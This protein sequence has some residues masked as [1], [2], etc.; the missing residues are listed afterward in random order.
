[1]VVFHAPV[2]DPSASTV[3]AASGMDECT[4]PAARPRTSTLR[5]LSGLAGAVSGSAAIILSTSGWQATCGFGLRPPHAS[6]GGPPGFAGAGG[7]SA[8]LNPAATCATVS[9]PVLALSHS[10][11]HLSNVA[12]NSSRV[13]APS[14]FASAAVKIAA[15]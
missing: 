13:I 8:A 5:G 10:V 9:V 3:F 14:L 12:F 15:P 6:G 11:Y 7:G 2:F 4:N 1:M